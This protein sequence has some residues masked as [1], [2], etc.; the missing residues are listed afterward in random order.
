MTRNGKAPPEVGLASNGL[1][2]SPQAVGTTP[3]GLGVSS[4]GAGT[5]PQSAGHVSQDEGRVSQGAGTTPQSA[6]HVSQDEGL[7]SQG[8]G[9]APQE[10]GMSPQGAG[11]TQQP[12]ALPAQQPSR[13]S[14]RHLFEFSSNASIAQRLATAQIAID[15]IMAAPELLALMAAQGYNAGRMK[16]GQELCEQALALC[17]QQHAQ[18]GDLYAATDA[19]GAAHAQ[20][21]AAYIRHCKL[22]KIALRDNRGAVQKVGLAV[23]RTRTLAGWLLQ[24]QQFYTNALADATI[25]GALSEYG[26]TQVQLAAGRQQVDVV[27]ASAVTQQIQRRTAQATT[28]AR[29]VALVALNHWMRDFLVVTRIALADYPQRLTQLGMGAA[30]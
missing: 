28:Q 14:R 3:Q 27:M 24:A 5:T 9:T 7:V 6:G 22:A 25:S 13:S 10:V 2:V 16:K 8:A 21:H 30:A 12:T 1:G 18:Y 4:Q 11:I 15:T 19:R 23:P 26:V 20:A 17:Q 29:D